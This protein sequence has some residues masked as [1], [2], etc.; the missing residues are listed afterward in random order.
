[1]VPRG[2]IPGSQMVHAEDVLRYNIELG[3]AV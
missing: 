1:M 2:I 3:L